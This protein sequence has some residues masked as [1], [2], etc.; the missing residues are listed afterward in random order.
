MTLEAILGAKLERLPH[1]QGPHSQSARRNSKAFHKELAIL[2]LVSFISVVVAQDQIA[3]LGRELRQTTFETR[4]AAFSVVR[5][6]L[7]R[8]S[9]L[10]HFM[11]RP[12]FSGPFS[13]H[14]AKQHARD[15]YTVGRKVADLFAF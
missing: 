11:Q 10:S 8:S 3:I 12:R 5:G 6:F 2:D 15:A 9:R 7:G 14:F 1:A 4:H 13:R